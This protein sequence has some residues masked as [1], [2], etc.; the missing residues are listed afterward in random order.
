MKR[1][2]ALASFPLM[3]LVCATA[4]AL[5]VEPLPGVSGQFAPQSAFFPVPAA[6]LVTDS[7]HAPVAGATVQFSAAGFSSTTGAIYFPGVGFEPLNDVFA[8]TG[9][10]GVAT[11]GP[12]AFGFYPG[13]SGIAVTATFGGETATTTIALTVEPGGATTID[14]VS[15]SHQRTPVGTLYAEPWVARAVDANRQPVPYAAVFFYATND[16]TLPS[17]T[18]NGASGGWVRADAQGIA[19]SPIPQANMVVG[20]EEGFATALSY[21]PPGQGVLSAFFAYTNTSS[22][23]GGGEGCGRQ[24]KGNGNCG[25]SPAHSGGNGNN[26]NGKG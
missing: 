8:T 1:I 22:T 26:G 11:T 23:G 21:M 2:L 10:D 17:V 19:V 14:L 25:K 6:V 7:N 20:S 12:G 13:P 5:T 18:F 4:A 9:A 15:G 16:P 3:M 24:G